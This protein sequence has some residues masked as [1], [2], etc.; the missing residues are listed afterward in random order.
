[1]EDHVLV[2]VAILQAVALLLQF[3]GVGFWFRSK[4]E[5]ILNKKLDQTKQELVSEIVSVTSDLEGAFEARLAEIRADLEREIARSVNDAEKR[6]EFSRKLE[7]LNI[8]KQAIE[9][10]KKALKRKGPR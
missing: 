8:A 4:L 10:A 7:A 1:M 5:G 9:E 2:F 3:L 6:A